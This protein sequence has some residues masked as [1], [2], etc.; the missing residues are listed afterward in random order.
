LNFIDRDI[1]KHGKKSYESFLVDAIMKFFQITVLLFSVI[2][3]L[4]T[5]CSNPNLKSVVSKNASFELLE[6]FEGETT[7][8]GLVVDRFGNLQRTFKVRLNGKRDKK[9]LLLKEYFTYNDGEREYREWV[10]TKIGT[11]SY[12]GKSKDTIGFAKGRQVGNTMRM[13]YD[14]TISVGETNIRVSF[15]DRFVKVDKKVVINRAEVSKWGI[16]I[17]DVTIFFSK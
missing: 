13:V 11:G 4:V 9:Q 2:L 3:L 15:D 14:T 17:A 12:E 7:A 16:K 1:V 10:I 5:G 8:W 6:Y